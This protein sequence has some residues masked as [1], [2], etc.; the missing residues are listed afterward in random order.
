MCF[1]RISTLN[2]WFKKN[3]YNVKKIWENIDDIIIKTVIIAHPYLQHSYKQCFPRHDHLHACFEILGFDVILD[4]Q[5][6]PYL[7]EVNLKFHKPN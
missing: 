3:N 4:H 1:R 2:E 6:K 7:L 5:L